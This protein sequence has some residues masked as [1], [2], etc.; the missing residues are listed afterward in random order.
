M[1]AMMVGASMPTAVV[2]TVAV[3]MPARTRTAPIVATGVP[4]EKAAIPKERRDPFGQPVVR[5]GNAERTVCDGRR[6]ALGP[7][8]DFASPTSLSHRVQPI[9]RYR[10]MARIFQLITIL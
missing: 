7:D 6:V 3:E 5:P 8:P 4:M 10:C 1:K 2:Q 9:R